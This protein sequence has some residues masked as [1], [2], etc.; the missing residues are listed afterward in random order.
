MIDGEKSKLYKTVQ[1]PK[2]VAKKAKICLNLARFVNN[3][4][5]LDCNEKTLAC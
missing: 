2:T 4:N 3:V 1:I 5:A